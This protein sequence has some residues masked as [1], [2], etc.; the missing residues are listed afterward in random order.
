M[1]WD[2]QTGNQTQITS[3]PDFMR[4]T[5]AAQDLAGLACVFDE[6]NDHIGEYSLYQTVSTEPAT[7]WGT[8]EQEQ[9]AWWQEHQETLAEAEQEL[10]ETF[11]ESDFFDPPAW[12]DE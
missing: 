2:Q 9:E 10:H 4:V 7:D 12:C 8:W 1:N 6:A 5:S 3:Y 11:C